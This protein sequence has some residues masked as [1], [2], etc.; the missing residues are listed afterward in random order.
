[1]LTAL[2]LD[3]FS[4]FNIEITFLAAI[5]LSLANLLVP[6]IAT[7]RPIFF[8]IR[9]L[10]D[11][12]HRGNVPAES[13]KIELARIRDI[14]SNVTATTQANAEPFIPHQETTN[15][16]QDGRVLNDVILHVVEEQ[17]KSHDSVASASHP[18]E[19]SAVNPRLSVG[20]EASRIREQPPAEEGFDH[21]VQ[22]LRAA[23]DNVEMQPSNVYIDGY[24]AM[25]DMLTFDIADLQ[26]LDSV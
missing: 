16:I 25:E 20:A 11:M 15:L 2:H 13:Y 8:A 22:D 9:M 10:Q 12:S 6:E 18:A 24:D 7:N 14:V 17:V 1:M 3:S 23:E 21:A 19:T 26:W 5:V 4:F